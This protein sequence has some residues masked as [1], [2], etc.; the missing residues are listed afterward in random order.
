MRLIRWIG[1]MTGR[2]PNVTKT[3]FSRMPVSWSMYTI[4]KLTKGVL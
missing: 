1:K 4:I 2:S 3:S